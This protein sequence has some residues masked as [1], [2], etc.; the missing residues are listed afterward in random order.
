MKN[1]ETFEGAR[2]IWAA[3]L[4]ILALLIAF[5][6]FAG[7]AAKNG[8]GNSNSSSADLP[9]EN[10]KGSRKMTMPE[11]TEKTVSFYSLPFS[12]I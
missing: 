5:I 4:I 7:W 2:Y 11:Y 1:N 8:N 3:I 6:A 9:S 10:Y 12:I